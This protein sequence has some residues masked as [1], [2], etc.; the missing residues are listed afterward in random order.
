SIPFYHLDPP[1]SLG[2][3]WLTS[4]FLPIINKSKLKVEDKLRTIYEHIVIQISSVLKNEPGMN[5]LVTGGGAFN[6][7]L[8]KLLRERCKVEIILP[9]EEVINFKEALIFAFLGV[10]RYRNEINCLSSVTGAKKDNIGG[11]EYKA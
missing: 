6:K 10:L 8:I 11:A 5:M 9:P 7:F 4:E 3:E 2:K 1:K